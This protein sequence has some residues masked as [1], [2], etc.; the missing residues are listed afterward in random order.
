MYRV[1]LIVFNQTLV[2]I[3]SINFIDEIK[4]TLQKF[5][6]NSGQFLRSNYYRSSPK[7]FVLL[8]KHLGLKKQFS[9]IISTAVLYLDLISTNL[10]RRIE[11]EDVKPVRE[12]IVA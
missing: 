1:K 7:K 9:L 11:K 2:K 3:F 8:F 6:E 4:E 10:G 5:L 12:I